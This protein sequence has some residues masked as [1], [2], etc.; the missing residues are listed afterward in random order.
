MVKNLKLL[1]LTSIQLFLSIQQLASCLNTFETDFIKSNLI[2]IETHKQIDAIFI[3][4]NLTS[5]RFI[6]NSNAISSELTRL[7]FNICSND[8]SLVAEFPKPLDNLLLKAPGNKH[9]NLIEYLKTN[10]LSIKDFTLADNISR[11]FL[12]QKIENLIKKF[13]LKHIKVPR[14]YL[15]HFPEAANALNDL[16]YCTIVQ[17]INIDKSKTL[18]DLTE[19]QFKE[20][21]IVIYQTNYCDI[22]SD[23]IV[24]DDQGYVFFIDLADSETLSVES[25]GKFQE[26]SPDCLLN[27]TKESFY[28]N[29]IANILI[30]K[31]KYEEV[32]ALYTKVQTLFLG[33]LV[34]IYDAN[35]DNKLKFIK[36][37]CELIYVDIENTIN[38]CDISIYEL[39][40]LKHIPTLKTTIENLIKNFRKP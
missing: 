7:G 14:K 28:E 15:Y 27:W 23:N 13:N 34:L 6:E 18:S 39:N 40:T 32:H 9:T 26:Y 20:V 10:N 38:K 21:L 17:K 37:F 11:V 22:H 2:D 1:L 16:N 25:S 31:Q 36:E 4:N 3:K 8:N 5:N 33:I 35:S 12:K 24:F 29:E 30:K 19:D